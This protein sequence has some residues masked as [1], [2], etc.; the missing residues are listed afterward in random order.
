MVLVVGPWLL[1]VGH[2]PITARVYYFDSLL[3]SRRKVAPPSP[4]LSSGR[5]ALTTRGQDADA[6]WNREIT[7][8]PAR[9]RPAALASWTDPEPTFR[10]ANSGPAHSK[11]LQFPHS[12]P[13]PGTIR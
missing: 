10:P 11:P 8:N 6:T 12:F 4:R 2:Q 13:R 7:A 9:L 1:A 5:L 3:N